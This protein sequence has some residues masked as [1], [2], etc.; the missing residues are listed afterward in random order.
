MQNLDK[1]T[2]KSFSNE[3]QRFQQDKLS[4]AELSKLANNYFDLFPL[5]NLQK[6]YEAF[7]MG[8]GTGRWAQFICPKI[9][10]LNCIDP[11]TA[12]DIAKKRLKKFKN[13]EFFQAPI[14]KVNIKENS[15]DF[16]YSLG[17]LHHIPDTKKA[18]S[19][20]VKILKPG[21]PF[22]IYIYYAFD[23]KPLWFK[24]IWRLSDLL[25]KLIIFLPPNLKN[26]ATD[27]LALFIYFPLAKSALFLEKINKNI[28]KNFPLSY[29]RKSSF[30]TMRT[31][32]RDRFGTPLEKR[33]TKDQIK[34]MMSES[35][36]TNIKFSDKE[37]F[38]CSLGYKRQ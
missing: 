35:G 27:F 20:C 25:R 19:D 1:S 29:Y 33:F 34:K 16:G 28:I 26:I 37:P 38:W 6:N 9:K 10:K 22:L 8:C 31:D 12:I 14:D 5:D 23:N 7:D 11:S 18:L 17:V 21:A 4:E 13:V 24:L 30:Y 36:L 15:Q 3:W 2:V 32:A